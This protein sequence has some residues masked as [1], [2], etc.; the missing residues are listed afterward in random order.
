[1]NQANGKMPQGLHA[2]SVA[3]VSKRRRGFNV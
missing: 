1:M 2:V 3:L